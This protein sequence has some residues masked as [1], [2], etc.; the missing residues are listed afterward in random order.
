MKIIEIGGNDFEAREGTA[1]WSSVTEK[2]FYILKNKFA[3]SFL[4]PNFEILNRFPVAKEFEIEKVIRLKT[5]ILDDQKIEGDF[6]ILDTQGSELEILKGAEKTLTHIKG[7]KIE[8]HFIPLYE[9]MPLFGELHQFLFERGFYLHEMQ[10]CY[11]KENLNSPIRR[12]KLVWADCI[13]WR[14]EAVKMSGRNPISYKG[15][16]S[17]KIQ[18]VLRYINDFFAYYPNNGQLQ[19]IEIKN[20]YID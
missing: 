12:G 7:L 1:L 14:D 11:W 15:R 18:K 4:K 9:E 8:T 10:R 20:P 2:N 13:Y 3:S 17:G 6:I 19:D 16:G 5:S